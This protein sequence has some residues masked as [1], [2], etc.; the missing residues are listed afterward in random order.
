MDDHLRGKFSGRGL[1][2]IDP[3]PQKVKPKKRR[4][5]N[6]VTPEEWDAANLNAR[7]QM[8]SAGLSSPDI[9][10]VLERECCLKHPEDGARED[11]NALD[12]QVGGAHYKDMPFQPIEFITANKLGFCEGNAIKYICRYKSKGGIQD[13]DKAIH[14]IQLL[15][16]SFDGNK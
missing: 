14:Y 3:P 11:K 6:D 7:N 5:L 8:K 15:K 13:L 2:D 9:W 1:H 16:E 12:N 10:A 4:S